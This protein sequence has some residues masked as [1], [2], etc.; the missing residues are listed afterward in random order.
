MFFNVVRKIITCELVDFFNYFCLLSCLFSCLFCEWSSLNHCMVSF[1]EFLLDEKIVL[2][3]HLAVW[4]HQF[5]VFHIHFN[6]VSQANFACSIWCLLISFLYDFISGFLFHIFSTILEV[7]A[8]VNSHVAAS[9]LNRASHVHLVILVLRVRFVSLY[10][11]GCCSFCF[12]VD[13]SWYYGYF[14]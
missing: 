11:V 13:F 9:V 7:Q 8:L 1:M 14:K 3:A 5:I 4:Y 10:S 12:L 6:A 2:I